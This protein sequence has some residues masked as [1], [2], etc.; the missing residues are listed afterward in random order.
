MILT[1]GTM[2]RYLEARMVKGD[3]CWMFVG[4]LSPK[5][6]GKLQIGKFHL[7]ANRVAYTVYKG[8]IPEGMLVK[9]KCDVP[10]CCNP[11]H[12]ELGT[13]ADNQAE[14]A[15][16]GRAA[17]GERHGMAKLTNIQRGEIKELLDARTM[18]MR[19]IAE[20]YGVSLGAIGNI[21]Y[22]HR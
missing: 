19:K 10:A 2:Q 16:R 4:S 9:H 13:D 3:G 6:Y 11:D 22:G 18:S 7:R 14:K 5:G 1:N 21:K 20:L 8:P 17:S 12:L 15:T